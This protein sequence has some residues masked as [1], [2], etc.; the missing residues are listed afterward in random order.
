M[1]AKGEIKNAVLKGLG[2]RPTSFLLRWA[3]SLKDP[4]HFD[5]LEVSKC[6]SD[7]EI[8]TR[9]LAQSPL[10]THAGHQ[11]KNPKCYSVFEVMKVQL[12]IIR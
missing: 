10:G 1:Y 9:K 12:R 11:L 4:F 2:I 7:G 3:P 6:D 8:V 5:L